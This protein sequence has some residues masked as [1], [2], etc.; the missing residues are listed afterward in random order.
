MIHPQWSGWTISPITGALISENNEVY[1][2]E[3]FPRLHFHFQ[4][5]RDERAAMRA[6]IKNLKNELKRSQQRP[7]KTSFKNAIPFPNLT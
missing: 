2:S 6:E 3:W 7:G 5:L 1:T 4:K